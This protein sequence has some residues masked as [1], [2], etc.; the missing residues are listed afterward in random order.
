MVYHVSMIRKQQLMG[1]S[2]EWVVH[3]APCNMS[4]VKIVVYLSFVFSC[5]HHISVIIRH[6]C[7]SVVDL[8]NYI[9]L[10]REWIVIDCALINFRFVIHLYSVNSLMYR[11]FVYICNVPYICFFSHVSILCT[12]LDVPNICFYCWCTIL[13]PF[14]R[15]IE[16]LHFS[17][18]HP[19]C[20]D[21][22]WCTS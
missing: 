4:C 16:Y 6:N 12:N 18:I 20:D 8:C 13:L 10:S 17:L 3:L 15:C 21:I 11:L 7:I 19:I 22:L 14:F 2:E 9:Y 5:V 1:V